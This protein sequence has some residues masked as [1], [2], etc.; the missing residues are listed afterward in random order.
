MKNAKIYG[1]V[2]SAGVIRDIGKTEQALRTR[3]LQH[4]SESRCSEDNNHRY[5]WLRSLEQ[6]P[7]VVLIEEVVFQT[8]AE[9]EAREKYWIATARAYGH[10]LVNATDGGEG[11]ATMLGKTFSPEH[12]AAISA[13][14]SG[15]PKSAEHRK[16]LSDSKKGVPP[17]PE[18]LAVLQ[19]NGR[20]SKG[21]RRPP[22]FGATISAAKTGV[23][24]TPEHCAAMGAAR[25]GK[26]TPW[27]QHNQSGE[28]NGF[29]GRRHTPQAIEKMRAAR[30]ARRKNL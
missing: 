17:T 19:A 25:K 3:L 7:T 8:R 2:D 12:R 22:E 5:N 10:K 16:N 20:A 4:W 30:R 27:L 18:Q 1:L 28:N 14:L 21:A 9:W 26:P 23:K 29:F 11:G 13:A 6:R 15:K 24:F